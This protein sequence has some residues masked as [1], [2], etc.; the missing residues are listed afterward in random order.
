MADV[1]RG[2]YRERRLNSGRRVSW[3]GEED[4][5]AFI[6]ITC[7]IDSLNDLRL[8]MD[9]TGSLLPAVRVVTIIAG[10]EKRKK[11]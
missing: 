5:S 6:D 3:I 10:D 11:M 4:R 9:E 7:E 2:A 1:E 8:V